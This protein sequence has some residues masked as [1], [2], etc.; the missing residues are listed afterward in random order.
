MCS[1]NRVAFSIF[2][3]D[4]AWYGVI[5]TSA[6]VI[7]TLLTIKIA[8]KRGYSS[9]D[10]IDIALW[11][12]PMAIVGARLYYVAFNLDYYLADPIRILMVRSGG[13]AI[14]GG[15]LGGVF[16][17]YICCRIKKLHAADLLDIVSMPLILAQ[18]IGRWGNYTNGEAHGGPTDLPWAIEVGGEMVHPT[19]LYESMWNLLCF[20]ILILLYRR[21]KNYGEVFVGY[22]ALYSFGRF[23][24]EGLRTDSLMF[25]GL[26]TAQVVSVALMLFSAVALYFIKKNPNTLVKN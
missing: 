17:G 18:A 24:I 25:F 23:F 1:I 9:D 20:G 16:G 13:L 7:A 19:F 21:R 2:G 3:I 4:I 8:E 22:M 15:V 12:I 10:I 14:H 6:I 26:R 11:A 5:I